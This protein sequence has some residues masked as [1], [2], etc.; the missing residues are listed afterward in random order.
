VPA[1]F[2]LL[3][4]GG[5]RFAR[6]VRQ[7]PYRP[8]CG[9]MKQ[10]PHAGLI[11]AMDDVDQFAAMEL[12]RGTIVRHNL[13]AFRDDSPVAPLDWGSDAWRSY[14]P[15]VPVSVVIVKERLPPGIAAAVINRAHSDRD[16]VCFLDTDELATFT[17]IDGG[18]PAADLP[19]TTPG[20]IERLWLHDL[21][22]IDASEALL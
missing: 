8:Q 6:W 16:L 12:F 11:A 14:V 17:A 22:V 5:M 10:L 4:R 19:G 21:V 3:E 18:T 2:D 15:L 9:I 1:L 7:A 20:L 13:I